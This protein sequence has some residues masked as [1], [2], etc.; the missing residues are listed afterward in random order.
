MTPAPRGRLPSGRIARHER[1][2]A[3][4]VHRTSTRHPPAER[5]RRERS[6]VVP[7][8]SL[9]TRLSPDQ[10]AAGACEHPARWI[11][12]ASST[13]QAS[14]ERTR[15]PLSARRV[16]ESCP[17]ESQIA[18]RMQ[19]GT[20]WR[21]SSGFWCARAGYLTADPLPTGKGSRSRLVGQRQRRMSRDFCERFVCLAPSGMCHKASRDVA[22]RRAYHRCVRNVSA[23]SADRQQQ[24]ADLQAL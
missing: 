10:G 5:N 16:G 13:T 21:F 12:N 24:S 9:G 2:V 6:F 23:C 7:M 22:V 18:T 4:C 15:S 8:G 14:P 11:R 19:V 17:N 20:T 3:R 1:A